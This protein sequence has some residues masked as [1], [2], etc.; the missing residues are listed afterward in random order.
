MRNEFGKS[1]LHRSSVV[2]YKYSTFA[3][4]GSQHFWVAQARQFS[5]SGRLKIYKR[6]LS[7]GRYDDDLVQIGISLKSH[8]HAVISPAIICILTLLFNHYL[9]L[10]RDS[11]RACGKGLLSL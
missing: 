6:L 8:L 2:R 7:S 10:S 1:V 5:V 3:R 4:G 9:L 11:N